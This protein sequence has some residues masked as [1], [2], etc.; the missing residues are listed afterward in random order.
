[1]HVIWGILIISAGIL[2]LVGGSKKSNFII[3]RF[4]VARSKI[5]W[6]KHV[7]RFH[8]IAGAIVVVFGIFVAFGAF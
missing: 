2:L 4:L 3:Y 7:Y 8:Q 1:M 5:L 6:G